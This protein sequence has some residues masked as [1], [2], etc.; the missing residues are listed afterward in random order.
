MQR[1]VRGHKGR[2]E[3]SREQRKVDAETHRAFEEEQEQ[4]VRL[5]KTADQAGANQKPARVSDYETTSAR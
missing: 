2:T 4:D 1:T 3:A 5:S